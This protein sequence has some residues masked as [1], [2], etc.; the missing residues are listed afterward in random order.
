MKILV[1]KNGHGDDLCEELIVGG[2]EPVV[3]KVWKKVRVSRRTRKR[4][5]KTYWVMKDTL[6]CA[7]D[8]LDGLRWLKKA[9]VHGGEYVE[10]SAAEVETFRIGFTGRYRNGDVLRF[11]KNY[12]VIVVSDDG[13]IIKGLIEGENG[14]SEVV[15][16]EWLT[17]G[18]EYAI[19]LDHR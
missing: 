3:V 16:I 10:V 18:G 12:S 9:W 17:P 11:G 7:I 5:V 6:F 4:I 8:D 1:A 2:Y 13:K 19:K 15:D 14:E